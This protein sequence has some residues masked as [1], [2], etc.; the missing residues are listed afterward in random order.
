MLYPHSSTLETLTQANSI[1]T[2]V[3]APSNRAAW[4]SS[5]S[6][7]PLQVKAAPYTTPAANEIVVKNGAIAINP[8]DWSK[9]LLGN[10]MFSYIKYPFVLGEDVAGEV[11]EVGKDVTRFK[12]GDR[13]VGHALSMDPNVNRSADG[14]FQEYTVL[15]SHMASPLPDALSYERAC[16]LPLCLSTA[17]CGLFQKDFLALDHPSA[18][19]PTP[20]TSAGK[21]G[22][23][24]QVLLV[25]GASTSVG[26]NAVQLAAAAGYEVIATAGRSNLDYVRGLGAA[27]VFDYRS[28]TVIRDMVASLGSRRPV[29]AVAVGNGSTEA[30]MDVL[31]KSQGRRFIAQASFP[32]PDQVPSGTVGLVGA[33]LSIVWWNLTTM[34]RSKLK[35]FETKFIFGTSLVTNEVSHAI[36]EDFLPDALA[37]G[38]YVT[39]PEPLVVGKGL[40]RVQD[41]LDLHMKGVSAKKVV[42]SL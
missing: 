41:A 2:T 42:V 1:A 23:N 26:S 40:E 18:S 39:A 22:K 15:K 6:E 12:P 19:A 8:I 34:I 38:S 33:M 9:Q 7:R 29:G 35:G 20:N 10:M 17:A 14:G 3:M 21:D 16:V 11:V 28:E 37:Q 36:Y 30:C 25:W 24:K 32:W 5:K 13:V 4:L 31:A 27:E